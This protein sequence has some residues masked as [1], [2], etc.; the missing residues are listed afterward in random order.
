MNKI[1]VVILFV[2]INVC[3][4]QF[5]FAGGYDG[6]KIMFVNSYHSGY[7]WS[8]GI[9]QGIHEILDG[10]GVI[11]KVVDMDTKRNKTEE[12]KKAAALKA[13]EAIEAFNPDVLIAADD[14]AVKYMVVPFIKNTELPVI[15]CGVNWSAD[16]YGLPCDNVTG[17]IEVSLVPGLID[18]LKKYANGKRIGILG[19]DNISNH[20]EAT[21]Y[22]NKFG[23]KFT[24]EKFV[25]TFE[26]WKHA[27]LELQD[28][29]DMLIM[30]PPSFLLNSSDPSVPKE[31]KEFI[32]NNTKIPSGCVEE[33]IVPYALLGLVKNPKEQGRWSAK[34]ALSVLDGKKIVDIPVVENEDGDL[35]LNLILAEK[36]EILFTSS[37][38]RNATIVDKE[39][40]IRNNR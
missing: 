21:N 29:V 13:K 3:L 34:A 11:L 15:F 33:W 37:M 4:E 19:A 16:E 8:D 10:T 6:K 14:N 27:Y 32:L 31:A 17:M 7:A 18:N 2:I 24:E 20:K 23:L 12:F 5:C 1:T 30:A 40:L 26:E 38:L 28:S 35:V 39:L 36:L 9:H 25:S 22:K